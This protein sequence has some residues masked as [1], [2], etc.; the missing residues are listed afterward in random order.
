MRFVTWAIWLVGFGFF[1]FSAFEF[2]LA[3][4]RT[5][6][7]ENDGSREIGLGPVSPSSDPSF[8]GA[9][10]LLPLIHGAIGFGLL[11]LSFWLSN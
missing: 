4:V 7:T 6:S 1:C 2:I 11:K 5:F 9:M 3:F 10:W 8:F